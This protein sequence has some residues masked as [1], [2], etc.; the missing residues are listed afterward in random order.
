MPF[1]I[2]GRTGP[3]MRQ[4][5]EFGIGPREGVL[6]GANFGRPIVSNGEFTAYVCDSAS[7]V[8][9][10]VLGWCVRWAEALL[11]LMGV[12]V[13]QGEGEVNFL[14]FVLHFHNGK[15]HCVADG[16]MF[17]IRMRK[18]HNISIR[19]TYRWKARF[20]GFFR[21]IQFQ[22]QSWGL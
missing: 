9:A 13:V 16:V 12:N 2:I 22:D 14:G 1:G 10:A 19:Q 3:E 11:Y 21:Y 20:V 17:P 7:T 8:G 15:C 5:V 6:L 4:V 18:L